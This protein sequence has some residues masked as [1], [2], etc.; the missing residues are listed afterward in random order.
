[1]SELTVYPD[2][3]D[4]ILI[5]TKMIELFG[6]RDGVRDYFLLDSA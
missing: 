1:M 4:V 6:G 5:H 3:S 2:V